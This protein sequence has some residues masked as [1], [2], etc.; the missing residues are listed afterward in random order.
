MQNYFNQKW[1]AKGKTVA[2]LIQNMTAAG[3]R[4]APATPGDEGAYRALHFALV[5]YDDG[6]TQVAAKP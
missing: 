5:A 1:V 6:I 3:L 2:E 4:F